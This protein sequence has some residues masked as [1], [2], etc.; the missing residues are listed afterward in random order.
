MCATAHQGPAPRRVAL[1]EAARVPASGT[2][3][4]GEAGTTRAAIQRPVVLVEQLF[5]T[6][7]AGDTA[8]R[9]VRLQGGCTRA[10]D[11]PAD[12]GDGFEGGAPDVGAVVTKQRQHRILHPEHLAHQ[13]DNVFHAEVEFCQLGTCRQRF[14]IGRG[15]LQRVLG[16]GGA[17]AGV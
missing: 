6:R 11:R 16:W 10:A 14:R 2:R 4:S 9:R 8:C 13:V 7:A 15:L 12:S 3:N 17:G 5:G 1:L